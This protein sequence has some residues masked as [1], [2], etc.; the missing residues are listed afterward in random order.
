MCCKT[1]ILPLPG[2]K[3]LLLRIFELRQ[4]LEQEVNLGADKRSVLT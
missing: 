3:I 2:D 1:E 4:L